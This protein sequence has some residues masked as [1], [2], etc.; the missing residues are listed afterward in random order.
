[1]MG[2]AETPKSSFN[3]GMFFGFIVVPLILIALLYSIYYCYSRRRNNNNS[4]SNSQPTELEQP[5]Y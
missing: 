1:M 2:I 5:N 4:N 3:Q